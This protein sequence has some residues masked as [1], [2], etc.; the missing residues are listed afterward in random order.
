MTQPLIYLRAVLELRNSRRAVP[1][2]MSIPERSKVEHVLVV[3]DLPASLNSRSV[4]ISS[5]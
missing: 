5:C 1:D 3:F 4:G 2:D